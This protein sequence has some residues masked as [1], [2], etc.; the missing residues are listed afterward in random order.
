MED[1]EKYKQELLTLID[2]L[3]PKNIELAEQLAE[4]VG[5]LDWFYSEMIDVYSYLSEFRDWLY[6]KDVFYTH[7]SP[8]NSSWNRFP[9]THKDRR[10]IVNLRT[11]LRFKMFYIARYVF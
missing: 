5:L 11:T 4:S 10:R 9:R 2:T 7:Y 1:L 3:E 6:T 8:S